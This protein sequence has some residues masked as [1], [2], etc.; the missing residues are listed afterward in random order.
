MPV[1][2]IPNADGFIAA[3]PELEVSTC[4]GFV[5]MSA[6]EYQYVMAYTQIT[7]TEMAT[8]FAGGFA[9][10]FVFGFLQTYAVKAALRVI[11]L[12]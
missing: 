5:M 6:D 7:S 2:A 11:R 9:L 4:S 12:I 10:V 8:Y 3:V 1:C